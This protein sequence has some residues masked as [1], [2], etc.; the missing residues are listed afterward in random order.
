MI[1]DDLNLLV[2]D[3]SEPGV[4]ELR[5][6]L[7]DSELLFVAA[8]VCRAMEVGN[9]TQA[10]SRLDEDEKSITLISNEGIRGNPSMTIVSEPGLYTLVLG[11]RKPEAKA[12]VFSPRPFTFP[13]EKGL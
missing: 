10:L 6:V 9:P 3:H 12:T 5:T 8:D 7:R 13:G 4:R 11:S 1:L 2:F